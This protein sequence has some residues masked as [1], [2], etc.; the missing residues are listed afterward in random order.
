[1]IWPCKDTAVS[2]KSDVHCHPP[3]GSARVPEQGTR[4]NC[5]LVSAGYPHFQLCWRQ[6]NKTSVIPACP[7]TC[8]FI[9]YQVFCP[10]TTHIFPAAD[11]SYWAE[12]EGNTSAKWI[13]QIPQLE[14]LLESHW[15]AVKMLSIP[16]RITL[17]STVTPQVWIC[18]GTEFKV[19]F[20]LSLWHPDRSYGYYYGKTEICRTSFNRTQ[21]KAVQ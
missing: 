2:M 14:T 1:M 8:F 21:Y 17:S 6:S 12:S 9:Q 11:S 13:L 15:A 4:Q 19:S 10:F 18:F 3:R 16:L 20:R 7:S 5:V